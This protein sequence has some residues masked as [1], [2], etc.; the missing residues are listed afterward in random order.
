[1]NF[2]WLLIGFLGLNLILSTAGDTAAKVWA[3]TPGYKWL[4]ITVALS[5]LASVTWMLV[6]RQSG[7]AVGGAIMLLFT[8]SSTFLIGFLFFKEPITSGQWIGIALG[9]IAILFLASIIKIG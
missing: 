6:V 2:N 8:L 1:M 7:L 3:I 9:F 4:C 5:G